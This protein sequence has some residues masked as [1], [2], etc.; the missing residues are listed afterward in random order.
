MKLA[1]DRA[2]TVYGSIA[3]DRKTARRYDAD[4]RLHVDASHISKANVCEYLGNEIPDWEQLGLAADKLYKLY[5]DPEELAKGAS[6]FNNNPILSRHVPVDASDHHPELVIGSTGTDAAFADGYLDNSLVFWA[7]EAISDIEND[8]KKELSSAYRYRADM[9]PGKS[10]GGEAYDGVMRDIVGNH[11]ALVKEGR[12]GP[13]V[14]VGDS[15]IPK[16]TNGEIVMSKRMQSLKATIAVGALIP[17]LKPLLA[18]DAKIDLGPIFA[19]VKPKT[20]GNMKVAIAKGVM[21]ATTGKLGKDAKIGTDG[22]LEGLTD[23]LQVIDSDKTVTDEDDMVGEDPDSSMDAEGGGLKEFLKGKMSE[24]DFNTACGM[25]K[26]GGAS[27]ADETD[28]EKAERERKEKEAKDKAAKDAEIKEKDEKEKSAKAMDAKIDAAVKAERKLANDIA[29]A[30]EDVRPHVGALKGAFDS[31]DGVYQAA[32]TVLGVEDADK[33]TGVPGLKAV[34]AAKVSAA[35]PPKP[36]SIA[37]DAAAT[38]SFNDR[39]PHAAKI[40]VSA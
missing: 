18:Q 3:F 37:Q 24:D 39:F 27:D 5:R 25:M 31:V 9:T 30:R 17:F 16:T 34:M 33:I 8:I 32:L 23:L 1:M 10:P 19:N 38:K 29:A 15:A 36:K 4:S 21:K 40:K 14:L 6:T 11:V 13:D 28:E 35:A 12:A 7:G 26:P 20:F 22:M 2:L